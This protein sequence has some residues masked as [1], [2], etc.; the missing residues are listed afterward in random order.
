MAEKGST[1]SPDPVRKM[2]PSKNGSATDHS[3]ESLSPYFLKYTVPKAQET[4][5]PTA[6]T[7]PSGVPSEVPEKLPALTATTPEKPKRRPTSFAAESGSPR[8]RNARRPT[9][10]GCREITTAAD[11][12]G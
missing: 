8:A 9:R 2:P 10:R 4:A 5:E 7:T 3:V 1:T 11:P 6:N 12:E